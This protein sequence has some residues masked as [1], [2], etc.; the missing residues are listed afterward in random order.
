LLNRSNFGPLLRSEGEDKLYQLKDYEGAFEAFEK[1]A[2]AMKG[3]PFLYGVTS[4]DRVYSGAAQAAVYLGMKKQAQK[5]YQNL[6]DL[7]DSLRK[8]QKLGS[9]LE[10]HKETLKWLEHHINGMP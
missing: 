9:S 10:W 4:P 7:F 5:Y 2:S 8:N 3:S 1:A 6:K